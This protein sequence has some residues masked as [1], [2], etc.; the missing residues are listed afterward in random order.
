[1]LPVCA[2]QV[3]S[4]ITRDPQRST[5]V[6]SLQFDKTGDIFSRLEICHLLRLT[7][8]TKCVLSGTRIKIKLE[9]FAWTMV[10]QS[11]GLRGCVLLY[12]GHAHV[13]TSTTSSRPHNTTISNLRCM[14]LLLY[15]D[16]NI[17]PKRGVGGVFSSDLSFGDC[18]RF[19]D[20]TTSQ[21]RGTLLAW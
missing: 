17:L 13:K 8:P 7:D 11:S 10:G 6:K 2:M 16:A 1:M 4:S 21:T 5:D 3:S 20:I 9:S 14:W 19:S 12:T 18:C 15:T